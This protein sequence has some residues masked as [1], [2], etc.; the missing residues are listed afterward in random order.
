MHDFIFLLFSLDSF[1]R[2]LS[3]RYSFT[4]TQQHST[5]GNRATSKYYAF[6]VWLC[7][8]KPAQNRK[9]EK[10]LR[11][12]NYFTCICV[13]RALVF[14]FFSLSNYAYFPIRSFSFWFN[15][16]FPKHEIFVVLVHLFMKKIMLTCSIGN[17]FFYSYVCMCEFK[18]TNRIKKKCSKGEN[19]LYQQQA[20]VKFLS[21]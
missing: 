21:S 1:V 5:R 15:F 8:I 18:C 9:E 19:C 16:L 6:V 10:T 2:S 20:S 11:V 4:V 3:S 14:S 7:V 17:D 12:L 13:W